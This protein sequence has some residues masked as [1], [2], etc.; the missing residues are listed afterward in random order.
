MQR[1]LAQDRRL[2]RKKGDSGDASPPFS[3]FSSIMSA[4]AEIVRHIPAT[5][6]GGPRSRHP[7]LRGRC[8]EQQCLIAD[9]RS[10]MSMG[11]RSDSDLHESAQQEPIGAITALS[12]P[13][14]LAGRPKRPSIDDKSSY[15]LKRGSMRPEAAVGGRREQEGQR[16]HGHTRHVEVIA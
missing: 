14:S 11:G 16:A 3:K 12:L 13:S 8:P 9:N 4:A 1:I 6:A 2:K 15:C 5:P 10:T 7:L